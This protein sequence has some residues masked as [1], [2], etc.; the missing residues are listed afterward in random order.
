MGWC[1]GEG[2]GRGVV[3]WVGGGFTLN[4]SGD[5]ESTD[6]EMKGKVTHVRR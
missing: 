5:Q 1:G 6:I 4:I 2:R 3:A